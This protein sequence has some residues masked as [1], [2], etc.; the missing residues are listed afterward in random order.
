VTTETLDPVTEQVLQI[1]YPGSLPID[2]TY[3]ANGRLSEANHGGRVTTY[4]YNTEGFLEKVTNSL[5]QEVEFAYDGV[6]RVVSQTLPNS[7]VIGFEYDS[8]GKMTSIQPP[9]RSNHYFVYGSGSEFLKELVPPTLSGVSDPKT[10]YHYDDDGL[11]TKVVRPDGKELHFDYVSQTNQ[12]ASVSDGT[13]S[14]VYDDY[15]IN[16]MANEVTSSDDLVTNWLLDGDFVTSDGLYDN[17]VSQF[18]GRTVLGYHDTRLSFIAVYNGWN[19]FTNG[20]S[21][22]FDND[23]L[24]TMAGN[25]FY[26]R[27]ATTGF[28]ESVDLTNLTDNFDYNSHGELTDYE[29]KYSSSLRYSYSLT[30]DSLGRISTMDETVLGVT[31]SYEYFYDSL[32]RLIEVKKDSTS[33]SDNTYGTNSTRTSGTIQGQSYTASYD[34]QDRLTEWND[35]EFA[36]NDNGEMIEK[37]DTG[38]SQTTTYDWDAWGRLKSVTL[39]NTTVVSYQYDG[40]GRKA[41][42]LVN[43]SLDYAILYQDQLKA[44]AQMDSSGVLIAR[45]VW[46]EKINVPEY[47]FKGG[48]MYRLVTDPRGSVRLV[49]HASNG[50]VAQRFDYDEWG[51]V[52]H[53]SN[54]GFQP[55]G[56]AGG[57]Y[58]HRTGLVQF[59]ARHYN[60]EVGR[61]LSKD[62]ILFDGGDTNLYGYVLN[63]PINFVDPTGNFSIDPH[64]IYNCIT[65]GGDQNIVPTLQDNIKR[66]EQVISDL[67]EQVRKSNECAAN[68]SNNKHIKQLERVNHELRSILKNIQNKCRLFER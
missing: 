1:N 52:T 7:D 21:Y 15:D 44:V 28:I 50:T 12:L 16:G 66:N 14:F 4:D 9:G 20:A 65:G 59:G 35:L 51:R 11:I 55:F 13:D 18:Y 10:Y 19:V 45:F 67:R 39:P 25:L 56:Y 31:T 36:Y 48:V 3:D 47:V 33:V 8:N 54:P 58:D 41:K 38:S 37:T 53:D 57:L 49:V 32:G 24:L 30:R 40:S 61:W 62:P 64:D 42:V 43:G 22:T 5:S 34:A 2:Y 27:D 63:D 26:T 60:A 29:S 23:G 68:D 46:G 6:G 17:K